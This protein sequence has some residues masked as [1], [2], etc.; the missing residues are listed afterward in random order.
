MPHPPRAPAL[1]LALCVPLW[2]GCAPAPALRVERLTIPG[3][4]LAPI[5]APPAP[6][7]DADDAALARW[8]VDL[9]AAREDSEARRAAIRDLVEVTP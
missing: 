6:A 3:R 2:T 1:L 4:L 5:D 9:V 7:P 8:I